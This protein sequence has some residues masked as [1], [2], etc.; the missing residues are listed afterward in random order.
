MPPSHKEL[1]PSTASAYDAAMTFFTGASAKAGHGA[2]RPRTDDFPPLFTRNFSLLCL[3]TLTYFFSFFFFFPTLPF[4]IKHLGGREA[5]VG[6]LIGIASLVSF[7]I[8]PLAG[9][10]VDHHGRVRLM[11]ASIALFAC[12]AVLHAWALRLELL[13]CLRVLYGAAL[14]CFTTASGAYLADVAPPARRGEATSSWGLVSSL[15]MG[16]V[17]PFALGLMSSKGL[18]PVEERLVQIL[19]GLTETTS[20]PDNFVLLFFTAAGFAF[21]SSALSC[22]MHEVHT[23]VPTTTKRPLYAREALLPTAVQFFM[24]LTFTSY[25]TFLPLYA[26]SLGM[27]NA[28]FL[29]STYALA[30]VSTRVFGARI[31]DRFGRS[32]VI[33]PGLVCM[34]VALLVFAC[35]LSPIFLYV[36]VSFYGLGIGLAQPGL[37]AFTIDRLAPDRRGLG[38]STFSQ[39]LDL[40][41]GLG[42]I[43][44][45]AIAA[46]FGFPIMYVCGSVCA[47]VGMV[48][49][50][51][52]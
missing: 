33:T 43:V 23:P 4:F 2:E 13:F 47:G 14:G 19:P 22:G 10:W 17:P 8:K 9:R 41:M 37:N 12:G 26:R 38:M 52:R 34:V 30:L 44:M 16:I 51:R 20:W 46:T 48:I 39:G 18:H 42:G 28:G 24:Y 29:Y 45:G 6:L 50:W 1:D 32:A 11:S 36:A 5:D 40:G 15:A 7:L 21:L 35:A 27:D 3:V 49:F 31:G 25:T